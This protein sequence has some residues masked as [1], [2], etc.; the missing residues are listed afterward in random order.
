MFA[1]GGAQQSQIS[2]KNAHCFRQGEGGRA[3][4]DFGLSLRSRI[5]DFLK[6]IP[7]PGGKYV[8]PGAHVVAANA[9][10]LYYHEQTHDQ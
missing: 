6:D 7:A 2:D 5:V 1:K 8:C 3:I 10:P 9:P 4:F